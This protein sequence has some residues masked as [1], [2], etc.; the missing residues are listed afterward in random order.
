MGTV[1]IPG[2]EQCDTKTWR[3]KIP[4]EEILNNLHG[5]ITGRGDDTEESQVG[6]DMAIL[7]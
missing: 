3:H 7:V 1:N 2:N 6:K 5:W 4:T